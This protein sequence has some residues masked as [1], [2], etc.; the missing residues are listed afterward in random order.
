[1]VETHAYMINIFVTKLNDFNLLK[2]YN[3]KNT[4]LNLSDTEHTCGTWF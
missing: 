2:S 3:Q 4:V 1:M